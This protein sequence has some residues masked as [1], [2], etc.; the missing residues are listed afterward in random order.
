MLFPTPCMSGIWYMNSLVGSELLMSG[1][2]EVANGWVRGEK[3]KLCWR[4]GRVGYLWVFVLL[5]AMAD[6]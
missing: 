3:S 6:G 1:G 5:W 2:L 4:M